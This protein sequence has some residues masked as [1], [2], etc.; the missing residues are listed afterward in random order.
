MRRLFSLRNNGRRSLMTDT[1]ATAIWVRGPELPEEVEDGGHLTPE[2]HRDLTL[3]H[4][5]RTSELV[6]RVEILKWA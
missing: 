6:A 2:D 3:D 4:I 1:I 5:E